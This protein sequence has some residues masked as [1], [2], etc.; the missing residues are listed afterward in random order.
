MTNTFAT[1]KTGAVL[2]ILD[3]TKSDKTWFDTKG[4]VAGYHS[5]S[6]CGETFQGQRDFASRLAKIPYDFRGKRVLDIGCSNGGLLH[7]LAAEIDFGVG[8]DF[9]ARCINGANA[10]KAANGAANV[11]FYAYDLDTEDLGLLESF[12]FFQPVD[13]CF[14]LNISLWVKRWKKVVLHCAS[15]CDQMVFESHGTQAE[16]DEQLLFVQS[17]YADALLVSEQSDD[18]PTYADRK[19]YLCRKRVT[20]AAAEPVLAKA[21][22]QRRDEHGIAQ[23]WIER[24]P[25]VPVKFVRVFQKTYESTVADINGRYIVKFPMAFRGASGI[26]V[27]KRVTDLLRDRVSVE[28]PRIELSG[29]PVLLS[30]YPRMDGILFDASAYGQLADTSKEE[31][32]AQVAAFMRTFHAVSEDEIDRAGIVFAPSW[33]IDI[34]R[35]EERLSSHPHPAVGK[36]LPEVVRNH[37]QLRVVGQYQVVGHF[38]LHGDNLLFDAAHSAL[39]GVIDFGNARRGDLHQDFAPLYLSSPDLA[40]RVIAA[41]KVSSKRPVNRVLVQHYVTA[42]YLHLLA[43][44]VAE[45]G[46]AHERWLA[47]FQKWYDYLLADRAKSRLAKLKPLSTMT[48]DWRQWLASNLMR[49]S[50]PA[51]LQRMAREQGF[52]DIDV[53]TEVAYALALPAVK[54][55][56]EILH[57]LKKREWLLR[58]LDS[59]AALDPRYGSEVERRAAPAFQIFVRDYYSKHL[60][61]VLTGGVDH[62]TAR[63]KWTP[64]YL[65]EHFGG[66]EVEVQQGRS[67]DPLYERNAGMHKTRTTIREFVQRVRSANSSN[68]FYM[69][70]NNTKASMPALTAMFDDLGDFSSG[71]RTVDPEGSGCFL[72]FGPRGTF[73]PLHHD[74][75]NNMLVQIYGRKKVVLAPAMQVERLYNDR[76]V[77]S[78]VADFANLDFARFPLLRNV[79]KIELEIGPGDALF[80][81]V[82]W[83]HCVEGLDASISVSFTDFNVSNQFFADFPR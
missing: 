12:V 23:A 3:K 59:L 16:R 55:G 81:P 1:E 45:G 32:A 78:S 7:Y 75:T 36:M 76:G 42:L 69:T 46:A 25:D 5:V 9:N 30:R 49:G 62:W 66:A 83:W 65:A 52:A 21:L 22:L 57:S 68:D 63:T 19:M 50:D 20:Q 82:G 58:T 29:E 72:W 10:I 53:A 13:V 24:F 43:D 60:P 47:E 38:D 26:E 14:I 31:L 33:Q 6:I 61:V 74:L 71:Y 70:A 11:H 28:I 2:N 4:L 44:D 51:V 27:E 64:E 80:I 73:T 34:D 15:L 35:V 41:Y 18:D 77:F 17:V 39:L 8:V 40:D 79:R 37:R 54:A 48:D 67:G 56:R